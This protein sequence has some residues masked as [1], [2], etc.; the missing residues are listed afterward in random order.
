ML[1]VV[2]DTFREA[3]SKFTFITFF[4][5]STLLTLFFLFAL[6]LDIVDGALAAAK[7]FGE[8]VGGLGSQGIG[9]ADF[10]AGIESAFVW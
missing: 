4:C 3:F 5:L 8:S 7:I 10:L 6:N 9:V 1:A 2:E